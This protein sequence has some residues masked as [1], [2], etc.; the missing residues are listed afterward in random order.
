MEVIDVIQNFVSD[1]DSF[2]AGNVI[3][4][5]LRAG[6]KNDKKEDLQKADW[7]LKKMIDNC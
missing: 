1:F 2:C 7:Y 6:K 3:K 5:V 4:Y